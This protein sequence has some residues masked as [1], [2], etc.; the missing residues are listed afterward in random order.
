[1]IDELRIEEDMKSRGRGPTEAV[2]RH[3]LMGFEEKY[4]EPKSE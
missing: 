2:Y 4:E 1:M 3:F